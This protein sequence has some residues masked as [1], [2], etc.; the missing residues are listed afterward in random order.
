M[1]AVVAWSLAYAVQLG[2]PT[3]AGQLFWQRVGISI[4]A[5]IPTVWLVLALQYTDHTEWLTRR[6]VPALVLDPALFVALV[7]TN[8]AH[9]LAWSV[10][11][12]DPRTAPM[13]VD[14]SFGVGYYAHI[15]YGY[16]LILAG[17]VL[18][19]EVSLRRAAVY[20]RQAALLAVGTIVPLGAN[21]AFTFGLGPVPAVDLTTFAFTVTGVVFALALFRFDLLNLTP[22]A[23]RNVIEELG[24]GLLVLDDDGTVTDHNENAAAILGTAPTP[25]E[26]ATAV[27]PVEELADADGTVFSVARDGRE[28]H[29][30]LRSTPLHDH[31][32]RVAGRA[33]ALREVTDMKAYEQ[34]LEVANRLLRHN[35]RN[36]MTVAM[37]LADALAEELDGQRAERAARVRDAAENVATLAEKAR[38][39][40]DTLYR[41][42]E[43]ERVEVGSLVERC[44]GRLR[45]SSPTATVTVDVPTAAYAEAPDEQLLEVAVANVVENA[46][47]HSDR[48]HPCV[49]VTVEA[50]TVVSIAVADDGPGIPDHETAVL[51]DGEETPLR[52]GSGVGLWLVN[53]IVEAA[54]GDV[55]FAANDPRGSVVT[56][57]L[58]ATDPPDGVAAR[59]LA[60]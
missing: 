53:W 10:L 20:R 59:S 60:R 27:L 38:H 46:I 47:E 7:W 23:R 54:G 29:F 5:T 21:V 22:V 43:T 49:E 6:T 31:R 34:R 25:G 57:T 3:L 17:I 48:E 13:V 51:L 40:E 9:E 39:M 14:L 55:T 58:P 26:H 18:V 36:E 28:C 44:A 32:D 2:Q 8:P 1:A 16:A 41:D 24:D 52:H 30:R 56:M 15:A 45:D 37:G 35:L 4:A 12:F 33:V 19:L 11:G 50:D 42:G